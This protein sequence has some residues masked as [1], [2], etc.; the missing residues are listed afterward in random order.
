M[1]EIK[2]P[3]VIVHQPDPDGPRITALAGPPD[4][5]HLDFS[6][7]AAD[8]IRQIA[9]HYGVLESEVCRLVVDEIDYPTFI[10]EEIM[11]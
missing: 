9:Q 1:K 5:T 4:A 10:D 11:Q 3:W 6:I 7:C 8:L 2:H